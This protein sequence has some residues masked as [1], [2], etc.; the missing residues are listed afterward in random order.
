MRSRQYD[1]QGQGQAP[2][3]TLTTKS[4]GSEC[5][6]RETLRVNCSLGSTYSDPELMSRLMQ[7]WRKDGIIE[8]H[9]GVIVLLDPKRLEALA[10]P[11]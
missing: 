5:E 11:R 1:G 2:I 10:E 7:K 6:L 3:A 9:R 4:S 8:E